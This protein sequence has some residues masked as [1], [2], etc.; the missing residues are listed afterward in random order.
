MKNEE[1]NDEKKIPYQFTANPL[2]LM[3]IMDSDCLK[4]LNLLIQEESYWRSQGRLDNGYFFKSINDLKE[5]MFMSNDK[6]VRLTIEALFINGLIDV[7]PQGNVHKASKFKLNME[8]IM[9]YDS[10]TITDVK[11]FAQRICK[12]PRKATCTYMNRNDLTTKQTAKVD[13]KCSTDCPPDCTPKLDK[14]DSLNNL[15]LLNISDCL[16]NIENDI[17]NNN[18]IEN[19][20]FKQDH[21]HSLNNQIEDKEIIPVYNNNQQISDASIPQV[22]AQHLV[23]VDTNNQQVSDASIPQVDAQLLDLS[24]LEEKLSEYFTN[25]GIFDKAIQICEHFSPEDYLNIER[26]VK[27]E[28]FKH[29]FVKD[30]V[31]MALNKQKEIKG[32]ILNQDN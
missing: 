27:G 1:L 12:L 14:S 29:K 18:I 19:K 13:T 2:N 31:L 28:S 8:K 4:L 22:D 7:I 17:I 6:D 24:E 26:I 20:N 21:S 23:L 25:E 32:N 5:D 15:D 11:K 30:T 3:Y 16:N 9:D 10:M